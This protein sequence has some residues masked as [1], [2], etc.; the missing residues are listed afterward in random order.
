MMPDTSDEP[1]SHPQIDD[2]LVRD[3]SGCYRWRN[4]MMH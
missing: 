3:A 4:V 1:V 2:L